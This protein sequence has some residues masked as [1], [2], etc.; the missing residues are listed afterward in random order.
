[1]TYSQAPKGT[2]EKKEKVES[3]EYTKVSML[4]ETKDQDDE[5]AR[6]S[7]KLEED[8]AKLAEAQKAKVDAAQFVKNNLATETQGGSKYTLEDMVNDKSVYADVNKDR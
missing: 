2:E 5:I 1:V 6:L 7:H 3:H 8:K 4:A